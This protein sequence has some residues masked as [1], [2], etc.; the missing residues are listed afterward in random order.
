MDPIEHPD[1]HCKP[2]R[3]LEGGDSGVEWYLPGPPILVAA[4]HRPI[5]ASMLY[6][7]HLCRGCP[8]TG[9]PWTWPMRSL[10]RPVGAHP[11]RAVG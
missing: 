2:R 11:R 9:R 5:P 3:L 8:T 10:Y 1:E 4:A 6:N 7:Q